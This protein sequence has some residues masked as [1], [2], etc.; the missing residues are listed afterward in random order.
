MVGEH[1][2]REP[3]QN[4]SIQYDDKVL[5]HKESFEG[6][7]D[8]PLQSIQVYEEKPDIQSSEKNDFESYTGGLED[9]YKEIRDEDR[10]KFVSLIS[11]ETPQTYSSKQIDSNPILDSNSTGKI[12]D[13]VKSIKG[14]TNGQGFK[15]DVNQDKNLKEKLIIP[16]LNMDTLDILQ[17]QKDKMNKYDNDRSNT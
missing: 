13:E 12:E 16:K 9:E 8:Q 17:N 11:V 14:N 4:L 15:V 1:L 7:D 6:V 3:E 10:S 5:E 2:G